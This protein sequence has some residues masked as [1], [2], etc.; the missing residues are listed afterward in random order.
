ML[1]AIAGA[2]IAGAVNSSNNPPP[3]PPGQY[4]RPGEPWSPEWYRYCSQKYRSFDPQT[5]TYVT[6]GGERRF[7]VMR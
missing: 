4:A 1:G 6:Y 7:C 3:P 2:A 5:G